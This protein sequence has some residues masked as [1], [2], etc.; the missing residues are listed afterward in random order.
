MNNQAMKK[1]EKDQNQAIK[2]Y[3]VKDPEAYYVNASGQLRCHSVHG[4]DL[5]RF[6]KAQEEAAKPVVAIET[7]IKHVNEFFTMIGV[8]PVANPITTLDE[9]N[10]SAIKNEY[11]LETQKDIIWMKFTSDGYLGVVAQSD[12]INYDIPLDES[13]YHDKTSSGWR[14]TT[15]GILIHKLNKKWDTS[16]VLVFPLVKEGTPYDRFEIETGVGNY[17]SAKGVPILDYYSHNY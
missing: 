2:N 6:H 7:I 16:F 1:R 17:L 10:Y 13:H 9:V 14:H 12:D 11:H 8:K 15:S 5:T 3:F 4:P